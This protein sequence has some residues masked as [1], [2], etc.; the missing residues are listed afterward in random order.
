MLLGRT[1]ERLAID[2]MLAGARAG[3]SGV[4][5]L[6]G[7]PGIGKTALLEYAAEQAGEMRMLRARGIESE[8]VIP[9]AGLA[10]LLRPLLGSVDEIPAPQAAALAGA[11]ALG[12]VVPGDRFAI[13]AATLSLLSAGGEEG[14]LLLLIDDAHWLDRSS[15]EALLFVARRLLA[16]PIALLL[17]VR[18]GE[19]SLLDGADLRTLRL[20]G[21]DRADA[22]EL[23]APTHV[24]REVLER[25]YRTTGGNPLALRELAPEVARLAG[26]PD[27]AP[28]PI[29]TSLASAFVRRLHDLPASTRRLLLL[30]AASDTGGSAV[31]A[32]AAK[33]LGLDVNDLGP[34]EEVSLI[35]I[36]RGEVEFSH[37]LVRGAVYGNASAPER[38]EVHAVL[39]GALPDRDV[40]QR[41][42]HLAA[43]SIGADDHA[44]EALARAGDRARERSAY[45][46]AATAFARAAGLASTDDARNRLLLQG[47]EAAWLAG[48]PQRTRD[49]LGETESSA[50]DPSLAARID[51]LRG[52]V[53]MRCGPVILGCELIIGAAS[54]IAEEEPELAVVMLAQAVHGYFNTGDTPA[55]VATAERAAT[56]AG[57][58]GSLRARF[59]AAM[60]RCIALVADG[61]GEA[62]AASARDAIDVLEGSDELRDD[63]G[64]LAWAALGPLWLRE[65]DTGRG[66]I[67]RAFERAREQAAVGTLPYLLHLRARDQATTDQWAAAEVGY[68]E[69]IRLGRETGQHVE[70]AAALAGLS[71]LRARQGREADC[72][73]HAAEA[74]AQCEALGI[75]L[76][77]VWA[78]QA[79]GD[80]ELGLSRP[81]E[82]I[83]HYEAQ[84]AALEGRGI[85]DVDLSPVPELVDCLLRVGRERD[86]AR[87]AGT[88][89][90]QAA[91][92]GQ[93]WSLAR[94]ARCRGMLADADELDAPFQEALRLHELTPDVF[95]TARTQLA[96]G[97][98]LR[99]ARKR[100]LA[101]EQLREA[102]RVFERLG[103]QSWLEQ[104]HT[105][106]SA[107]GE[108]ARRRDPST[109]DELTPQELRI[110]RLLAEGR[111]TREAAAAIFL[112]PKTVE[113]HL[114][115][116]YRK[117]GIKSREELA[118]AL[119]SP[120]RE[121]ASAT[122]PVD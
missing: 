86:A 42:W 14:P 76:Y 9:F 93:P 49:L 110:A 66:L 78:I 119:S 48:D 45:A 121:P 56:I 69:A 70:A 17:T 22:A 54:Q 38:R 30:L 58:Q 3:R 51:Y 41:A 74:G 60:S 91:A 107:T 104:A 34:A 35:S 106:L 19:P 112:S 37:P 103:A 109:L 57:V 23:L 25:L 62:G 33:Q 65:A 18:E 64:L 29:S 80:L 83:A 46:V 40:D 90:A 89:I 94:A 11:L 67:E 31:L 79:L 113:Y 75:G 1:D 97:A 98:R 5:A 47:G 116:V 15:A 12:P 21:L 85:A 102:A 52:Q 26:E 105:E 44:S 68:D 115:N 73:E 27:H 39:A 88:F 28:I 24:S 4:L 87:I 84:A 95:E 77:G 63:P 50:L 16:D 101:R 59:F 55:M 111:T 118:V 72:R 96:Y 120:D 10:E 100:I 114:G 43:A 13:G 8:A 99:R 53:A 117:L 92:K 36:D 6:T 2:R 7:E 108:T 71:W 81:A 122:A 61:Q 82:A 20:A 32:R